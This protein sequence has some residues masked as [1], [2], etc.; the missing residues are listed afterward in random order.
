MAAM[1]SIR[2]RLHEL[3]GPERVEIPENSATLVAQ[4]AAW[5]ANDEQTLMLE[6]PIELEMA[7]GSRL[8]LLHAGTPMPSDGQLRREQ[9]HLYC[10]D[11]TDGTAKFAIVTPNRVSASHQASDPRDA[12]VMVTVPVDD[13][14][15]VA[16]AARA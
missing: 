13:R 15:A 14:P 5:I 9:F 4:G 16:R 11:P 7:T 8:P 2:S 10:T 6:K 12:V 3:F 1:P